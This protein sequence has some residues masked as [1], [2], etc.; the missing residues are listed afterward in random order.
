MNIPIRGSQ[1]WIHAWTGTVSV[2]GFQASTS[3]WNVTK[4]G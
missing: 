4:K 3:A 2:N 1:G